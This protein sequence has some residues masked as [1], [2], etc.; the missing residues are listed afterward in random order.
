MATEAK[1]R[2][3]TYNTGA[4]A[5]WQSVLEDVREAAEETNKSRSERRKELKEYLKDLDSQIGRSQSALEKL[6][7]EH[8]KAHIKAT[9]SET[10]RARARAS[11]GTKLSK[12]MQALRDKVAKRVGSAIIAPSEEQQ[13]TEEWQ[14][15]LDDA[16][17]GGVDESILRR[18]TENA[19]LLGVLAEEGVEFNRDVSD[20]GPLELAKMV[21]I[22]EGLVQGFRSGM[23]SSMNQSV[24]QVE[25]LDSAAVIAASK[26]TGVDYTPG[27]LQAILPAASGQIVQGASRRTGG[28]SNE[29][30]DAMLEES[31]LGLAAR[32]RTADLESL[33][34]ERNLTA[35]EAAL[36]PGAMTEDEILAQALD[37]SGPV[38]SLAGEYGP[39]IIGSFQRRG[40]A[41]KN[42]KASRM[43]AEANDAIRTQIESLAPEQRVFMGAIAQAN[44]AY[45]RNPDAFT[46]MEEYMELAAQ[47]EEAK[48]NDP[49]L[50]GDQV[51][52]TTL[53]LDLAQQK[54]PE[55]SPQQLQKDRDRILQA[56]GYRYLQGQTLRGNAPPEEAAEVDAE[57]GV[58]AA[59]EAGA[60][61]GG[62]TPLENRAALQAM[63]EKDPELR[64]LWEERL[65]KEGGEELSDVEK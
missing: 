29:N 15:I 21:S 49:S 19:S 24:D 28:L 63:L 43:Q 55:G 65:A 47:L 64:A 12:E 36:L 16:Q 3:N 45:R 23:S 31:G 10:R 61:E 41:R 6:N 8:F 40:A 35:R 1:V 5:H 18:V 56:L 26:M 27:L 22:T 20:L 57:A 34:T 44:A 42:L 53:A 59:A 50:R 60:A 39:G 51:R 17:S 58:E 14:S 48:K 25:G 9:E 52:L 13:V 30:I 33:R 62:V 7:I 46:G 54:N 32:Q 37:R 38:G 2:A 11:S 4:L